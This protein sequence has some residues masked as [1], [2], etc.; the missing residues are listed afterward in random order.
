MRLAIPLCPFCNEIGEET[1]ADSNLLR[2]TELLVWHLRLK[3]SFVWL[4]LTHFSTLE[5]ITNSPKQTH[6]GGQASLE[7]E[8][9]TPTPPGAAPVRTPGCE[10]THC[11]LVSHPWSQDFLGLAAK[12]V[13]PDP[14]PTDYWG[15]SRQI[16]RPHHCPI[17]IQ[18]NRKECWLTL[19]SVAGAGLEVRQA[20]AHLLLPVTR[21]GRC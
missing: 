2:V 18:S 8:S 6:W 14:L 1:K 15:I 3:P 10:V 20:W 13:L 16:P 17:N 5:S 11:F 9:Q 19:S 21:R 12:R 4:M 7:P